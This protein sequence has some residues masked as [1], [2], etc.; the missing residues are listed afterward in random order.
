MTLRA[1]RDRR[2]GCAVIDARAVENWL[3][4]ALRDAWL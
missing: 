3:A 2:D 4:T 1:P